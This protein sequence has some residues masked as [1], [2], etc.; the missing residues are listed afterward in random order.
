MRLAGWNPLEA[1]SRGVGSPGVARRQRAVSSRAAPRSGPS[2]FPG[3]EAQVHVGHGCTPG[4]CG[5]RQV[6][7]YGDNLYPPASVTSRLGFE[8]S[9]SIFLRNR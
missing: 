3:V 8:G 2:Y 4:S 5:T 9:V 6:R 7:R 1:Q